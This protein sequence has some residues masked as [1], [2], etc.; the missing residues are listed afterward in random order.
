MKG[1]N[2]FHLLLTVWMVLWLSGCSFGPFRCTLWNA[3]PGSDLSACDFSGKDL[4]GRDLSGANLSGANLSKANLANANLSGANL[5]KANLA[6]AN[7]RGANLNG[8]DLTDT[9]LDNA[10]LVN[11][12]LSRVNLAGRDFSG[13]DFSGVTLTEANLTGTDLSH[14]NLSKVNL[15]NAQLIKTNLTRANLANADFSNAHLEKVTLDSAIL[16]NAQG[17][18]D[19]MLAKALGVPDYELYLVTAQ[20]QIRLE[21]QEDIGS[22]LAP[23]CRDKQKGIDEAV[24]M[25]G[26]HPSTVFFINNIGATLPQDVGLEPMAA[27]FAQITVC[28]PEEKFVP[29]ETCEYSGG[30]PITRYQ[31]QS[32]V[33]LLETRTGHILAEKTIEGPEPSACPVWAP[34]DQTRIDGKSVGPSDLLSAIA[35]EVSAAAFSRYSLTLDETFDNNHRA[36][37]TGDFSGQ[38]GAG[39]A[40]IGDGKFRVVF[41]RSDGTV[42]R[43]WLESTVSD[44][45]ASLE[46][47]LVEGDPDSACYGISFRDQDDSHYLYE[48]CESGF[49][50][51]FLVHKSQWET[52]IDWTES[53]AINRFSP[54]L[55]AIE[56]QGSQIRLLINDQ[57]V[58]EYHDSHL[59]KGYVSITVDLGANQ[60]ATY[61]FDNYRL[62][63]PTP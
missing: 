50:A 52:L 39:N 61:E 25:R 45:R 6:N 43:W 10:I 17:L 37:D 22:Q 53:L 5:S 40:S 60:T 2:V 28:P 47:H 13:T 42:W 26:R 38:W 46:G 3:S 32:T 34:V 57:L 29:I 41:T 48:I 49:F 19:S 21:S 56:A 1:K 18:T 12:N 51:L 36:W 27:R 23:L 35:D 63:Y 24:A 30:P 44:F 8:A 54:N 9:V 59:T 31:R 58:G 7:L 14:A 62:Y 4:S 15:R 20:R 55:L 33:I 16:F 11:A